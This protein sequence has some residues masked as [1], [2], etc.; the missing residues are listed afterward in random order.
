MVRISC[1]NKVYCRCELNLRRAQASRPPD[2]VSI[3][4]VLRYFL[5]IQSL[6]ATTA[7]HK[8]LPNSFPPIDIDISSLPPPPRQVIDL[9]KEK[10]EKKDKAAALAEAEAAGGGVMAAASSAASG[11][12][13]AATSA[14]SGAMAVAAGAVESAKEAVVG[15]SEPVEAKDGKKREKREKKEKPAKVQPVREEPQAPMP[16]MIDMRVGK[17]LDGQFFLSRGVKRAEAAYVVKRHPDADSLYV[18][19]IDIGEAEPR[20]VCSGLVKYMREEDIRGATVIVIVSHSEVPLSSS[21][22]STPSPS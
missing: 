20:T 8:S 12:V 7:A 5:Q 13:A 14:A 21:Y 6:P 22:A 3:P 2:F 15:P 4:S 19:Q 17:V 9:K 18:E 16:S 11:A 10:K 1:P